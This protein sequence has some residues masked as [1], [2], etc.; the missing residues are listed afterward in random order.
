MSD[1]GFKFNQLGDLTFTHRK[2]MHMVDEEKD[3]VWDVFCSY[4][5]S[6]RA[7]LRY[8]CYYGDWM[9]YKECLECFRDSE[10]TI[11]ESK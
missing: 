3:V 4:H 11:K 5:G 8:C 6:W 1:E 9:R 2:A 7:G 10:K